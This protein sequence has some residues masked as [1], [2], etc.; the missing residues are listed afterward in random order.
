MKLRNIV[1]A[2][3]ERCPSFENRV[4]GAAEWTY[5]S[6]STASKMP[7]AFVVPL[8]ESAGEQGSP[9]GY[10]QTVENSFAVL[11]LVTMDGEQGQIAVDAADDLRAE[12]FR[13]VLGWTP[14]DDAGRIEFGGSSVLELRRD[15]LVIQ[16]EFSFETYLDR[17]DVWIET[18][19]NALPDLKRL[20]IDVDFIDPSD[21]RDAPD[22][23]IEHVLEVS[24]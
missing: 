4:G 23:K 15:R 10:R 14:Y 19:D 3:R 24:T 12:I 8:S 18:R 22:G 6:P 21:V 7:S 2:L 11:V 1:A 5:V 20:H 13:A 16:L 17:T 9:N